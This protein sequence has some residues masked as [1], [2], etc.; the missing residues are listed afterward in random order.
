M[1]ADPFRKRHLEVYEVVHCT[2]ESETGKQMGRYKSII[3]Y[4][5]QR[6]N[7]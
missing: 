5:G 3:L 4:K 6:F 7:I 1:I 2:A